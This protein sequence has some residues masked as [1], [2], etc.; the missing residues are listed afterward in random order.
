M[1]IIVDPNVEEPI[2]IEKLNVL[3]FD[4]NLLVAREMVRYLN[5][6]K[7]IA[8]PAATFSEAQNL[9]ENNKFDL[10]LIDSNLDR[11]NP[12][13]RVTNGL[14]FIQKNQSLLENTTTVIYSSV[15]PE[16]AEKDSS[17]IFI[18]R[19]P[20]LLTLD[21]FNPL[22][23]IIQ[24]LLDNKKNVNTDNVEQLVALGLFGSEIKLVS[25]D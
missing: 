22:T 6:R 17:I 16:N 21:S 14:E 10:A 20:A 13:S 15:I 5:D 24:G 1:K 19:K 12:A 3:V 11:L 8:T 25:L 2:L 23:K 9:L 18:K 4:D 7:C